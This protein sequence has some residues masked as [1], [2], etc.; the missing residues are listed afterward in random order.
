MLVAPCRYG[1][2]KAFDAERLWFDCQVPITPCQCDVREYESC[3][4]SREDQMEGRA[5][6]PAFT[7]INGH[8]PR[9]ASPR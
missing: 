3:D 4:M 9:A 8:A 2:P 5:W 7:Q 6:R 1:A